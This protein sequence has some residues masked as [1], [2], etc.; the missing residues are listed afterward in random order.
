MVMEHGVNGYYRSNG[1]YVS[2]YLRGRPLKVKEWSP[3]DLL[4]GMVFYDAGIRV[5]AAKRYME[6]LS[7]TKEEILQKRTN[8]SFS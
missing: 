2:S 5:N 3:Y 7:M 6:S 1:T 4:C 8:P